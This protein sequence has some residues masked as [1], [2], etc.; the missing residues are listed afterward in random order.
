MTTMTWMT[1][2]SIDSAESA[3]RKECVTSVYRKQT[4]S[5][6]AVNNIDVNAEVGNGAA[7]A[8]ASTTIGG[9]GWGSGNTYASD[10]KSCDSRRDSSNYF[11]N[12]NFHRTEIISV[13]ALPVS[14]RDEWLQSTKEDVSIVKMVLAPISEL[15]DPIYVN[16]ILLDPDD[17]SQGNLDGNL[18][19][20]S[21]S[22]IVENYCKITLGED[23]PPAKGCATFGIC[24]D[25]KVCQDDPQAETGFRCVNA[26]NPCDSQSIRNKCRKNERCVADETK[27]L[28]YSCQ[29]G[30]SIYNDCR[31]N[32]I[33]RDDPSKPIGYEC[34]GTYG[35]W[36]DWDCRRTRS[37]SRGPCDGPSS[38][39][40]DGLAFGFSTTCD[41]KFNQF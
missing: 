5:G 24:G 20:R 26:P 29:R 30:C 11:T 36:T 25:G 37:C 10:T 15:F 18:L 4:S 23:C 27:I 1:S 40:K 21:F 16:D 41:R 7:S 9:Q 6:V 13:G 28:G 14:D 22:N 34:D 12:N 3:R 33:C 17:P 32:E 35:S 31:P 19:R 39:I 38:Q 8:G 2:Q